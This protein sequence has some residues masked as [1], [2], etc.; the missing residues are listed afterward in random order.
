MRYW[1]ILVGAVLVML[2][3]ALVFSALGGHWPSAMFG[4]VLALCANVAD[5]ILRRL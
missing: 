3:S 2:V 5:H 1:T 4:F